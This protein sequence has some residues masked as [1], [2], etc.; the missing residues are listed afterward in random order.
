MNLIE[1]IQ[2]Q[3]NRCRELSDVYAEI[4]TG[5]YGKAVIDNAIKEGEASIASG[6]CV[7]MLRAYKQLDACE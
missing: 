3:M 1:G 2:Q 6:D 4:P 5:F 7:R